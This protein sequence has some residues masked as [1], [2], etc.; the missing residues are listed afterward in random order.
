MFFCV[1]FCFKKN[2]KKTEQKKVKTQKNMSKK[3]K[4]LQTFVI[5]EWNFTTKGFSFLSSQKRK[6]SKRNRVF[7]IY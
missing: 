7:S 6:E 3:E 5:K 2:Q 4:N 1:F